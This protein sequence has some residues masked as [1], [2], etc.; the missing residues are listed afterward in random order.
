MSH[1]HPP[2]PL[3]SY[4]VPIQC[5]DMV[6]WDVALL[7]TLLPIA[8]YY[9]LEQLVISPYLRQE[10]ERERIEA[11]HRNRGA[12]RRARQE[13]V[14]QQGLMR[15]TVH[16]RI[17]SEERVSGLVIVQALYGQ[18]VASNLEAQDDDLPLATD[19]TSPLQ[20]LVKDHKLELPT[21]QTKV[22]LLGFYDPCPGEP[23]SLRVRYR[24]Q[25]NLH[26]VTVDDEGQLRCPVSR[27]MLSTG[28]A[29]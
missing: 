28:A 24:F 29:T 18:L 6:S 19:V 14:T 8:T 12:I 9:C 22:G 20:C 16:R 21:G 1:H 17:E 5:A 15:E 13:A 3:C 11:R 4:A 7:A 23:K 27:H 25:G 10:E 26:E 2:P